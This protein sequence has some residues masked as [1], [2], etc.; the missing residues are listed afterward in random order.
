MRE[1]EKEGKY[2]GGYSMVDIKPQPLKNTGSFSS[3]LF[4]K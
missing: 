1:G 4:M 2:G 3:T